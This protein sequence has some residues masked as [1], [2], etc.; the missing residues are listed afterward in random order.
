M[1]IG[2]SEPR[3]S[4]SVP[5]MKC[6]TLLTKS[7]MEHFTKPDQIA[8]IFSSSSALRNSS[9]GAN[10]ATNFKINEK[11]IPLFETVFDPEKCFS[12]QFSPEMNFFVWIDR[13]SWNRIFSFIQ[14]KLITK[15]KYFEASLRTLTIRSRFITNEQLS[16]IASNTKRITNFKLDFCEKVSSEGIN[17]IC[18]NLPQLEVLE[19]EYCE[20]ADDSSLQ[21]FAKLQ[22]LRSFFLKW[23]QKITD[24]GIQQICK[25]HSL[26]A[27]TIRSCNQISSVGFAHLASLTNLIELD[28]SYTQ[29]SDENL[30]QISSNL[31]QLRKIYLDHCST[32]NNGLKHLENLADN[33]QILNLGTFYLSNEGFA[34]IS[35]LIN[36]QELSLIDATISDSG[37]EKIVS[38]LPFLI[39]LNLKSCERTSNF[40]FEHL[41]RMNF[42]EKFTGY[43]SNWSLLAIHS[44]VMS[45]KH[46]LKK[47]ELDVHFE[48]YGLVASRILQNPTS[49]FFDFSRCALKDQDIP[50]LLE[51]I[52][53]ERFDE[54][55]EI[56][57][58]SCRN[59]SGN[60]LDLVATTMKNLKKIH[61]RECWKVSAT[62][63]GNFKLKM[64]NC[65]VKK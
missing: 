18:E 33:L 36:L 44:F 23:N 19:L 38:S 61:L 2:T 58:E 10:F 43:S 32:S 35:K 25:V 3:L 65:E 59:I 17:S 39:S 56:S 47:I 62:V 26:S 11:S 46:T 5:S 45:K 28:V 54:I 9:A 64:P 1:E 13:S 37:V 63:I 4:L 52:G 50:F 22:K 51:L 49:T 27:L 7:V 41:K 16:F 31:L 8:A 24:D 20:S 40:C 29:F 30:Q 55:K 57:F 53:D 12:T 15:T 34:S 42:L 6:Q 60:T 21:N 48:S 14:N